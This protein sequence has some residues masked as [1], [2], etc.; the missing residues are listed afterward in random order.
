MSVDRP[1]E[2]ETIARLLRPLA[3]GEPGARNLADDAAVMPVK[4]GQDL[5]LTKDAI[6]EGVHFL[7]TDP[8]DTV[9]RKA[10]R[11]NLSDLAAKGADPFGYLLAVQWRRSDGWDE[12]EAFAK[13]LE[14]DRQAF[15]VP[16]LGGDTVLADGPL[17]ISVT[18]LGW[19]PHGR[20]PSRAGAKPGDAIVVSGH[21]GDG[22]LGLQAARGVLTGLEDARL[23]AL[24]ARY[25]TP[26]P[27]L[28]LARPVREHASASIDIS[29]GLVA[30]LGHIARESGVGIELHLDRIPLSRAARAWFE[31]RADPIAALAD[32]A[33]G[34]DDYEIA[35]AVRADHLEA[36]VR[37][38]AKLGEPA[39]VI[40]RATAGEG[41]RVLYEGQEARIA[42]AGWTHQ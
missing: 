31:Q 35:C 23:E 26:E 38:A 16:L 19:V 9:A 17:V 40:G 25:R 14:Q 15:G 42:R 41:V 36:Y 8:L 37:T 22:W 10:L 39:T 2:F 32:L 6:V 1:G 34:G 11:V 33:S 27:R 20:S 29:D 5:V 28:S 30:D 13:G 12:R 4:P 18:A 7:S 3:A 24:T 21:I